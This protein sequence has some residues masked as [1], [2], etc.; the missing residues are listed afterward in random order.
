MIHSYGRNQERETAKRTLGFDCES[1]YLKQSGA[2]LQE[3]IS[4]NHYLDLP[5]SGH[6][7]RD[8]Q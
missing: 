3:A 4:S 6:I 7:I 2:L 8:Q 5:E 1:R